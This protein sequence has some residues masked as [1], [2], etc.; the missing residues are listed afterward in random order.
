M[1]YCETLDECGGKSQTI[2]QQASTKSSVS[3]RTANTSQTSTGLSMRFAQ[4]V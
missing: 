3:F 4:R 1:R 2:V